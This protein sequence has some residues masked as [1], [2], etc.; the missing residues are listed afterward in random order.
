MLG[1]NLMTYTLSDQLFDVKKQQTLKKVVKC[2]G[3][4]LHS[5]VISELAIKP[6]GVNHGIV[7]KRVDVESTDP[8]VRADWRLVSDTILSTTISNSS[9]ISVSTIEHLMA[10]FAGCGIDNVLVEINGPEVPIMDGSS[11]PFVQMLE[12]CGIEEQKLARHILKILKPIKVTGNGGEHITLLPAKHFSVDFEIDF[13]SNAIREKTLDIA[14]VNGTFN[15]SISSARTF[16]FL[17]DVDKMRAA[18]LGLGGSLENVVVVDGDNIL[19]NGGLRY[20][21]EF[22]RHKILDCVGDLYLSGGPILGRITAYKSGHHF[23]NQL[24]KKLFMDIDAWEWVTETNYPNARN[25]TVLAVS[26]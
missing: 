2:K 15:H 17:E 14:L 3:I 21:D 10:A 12:L 18:G 4:A 25:D 20:K 11:E 1:K 7:F 22:V 16:G 6:A 9:E 24:L 13:N 5:G 26:A 19:N 23:N 8:F